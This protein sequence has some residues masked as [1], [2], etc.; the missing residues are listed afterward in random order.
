MKWLVMLCAA[1]ALAL[2]QDANVGFDLRATLSGSVFASKDLTEAPRSGSAVDAGIRAV[3]Y[4]T[5]KFSEHWSLSGALQIL[6]QPYTYD[7]FSAQGHRLKGN[8][9]MAALAYNRSWSNHSIMLRAGQLLTAFGSFPLRYD[10][11]V[12]PLV[13]QPLQYSYYDAPVTTSGLTGAQLDATTGKWDG[14]L[15]FVNSSPSNPRSIFGD[16]QFGNWAGGIG[17]T[18][19]QGF[20]LGLSA[21]RGPYLDRTSQ[22]YAAGGVNAGEADPRKL[23]AHAL[24]L[25]VQWALGHW[26]VQG[27]LQKFVF[28]HRAIASVQE[29]AGYAEVKR[30]LHPRWY[31][32]GRA[33]YT[34]SRLTRVH[35]LWEAAVGL[36]PNAFQ[37]VKFGYL[38][39][40]DEGVPGLSKSFAVQLVTSLHPLSLTKP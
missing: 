38:M 16:G 36:R 1:P 4:P 40:H 32:A 15:Q 18:V 2:A 9:T 28:P 7:S 11:A 34:N 19:R 8:L 6:S 39:D 10:D 17:Y 33:G 29:Q 31:V 12:N 5:W 22:L 30:V 23:P 35:Q 37:I 27:E 26:N 14:R 25:D 3:F 20:R 24:G 13:N 21:E